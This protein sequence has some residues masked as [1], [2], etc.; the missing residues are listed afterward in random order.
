MWD[1]RSTNEQ[2]PGTMWNQRSTNEPLQGRIS[3]FKKEIK[4]KEYLEFLDS[5]EP[6]LTV[7]AHYLEFRVF[8][9]DVIDHTDLVHRVP[10]GGVLQYGYSA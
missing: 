10:L 3:C 6:E 7:S 4:T 5:L 9:F 8:L 1:Q 2:T